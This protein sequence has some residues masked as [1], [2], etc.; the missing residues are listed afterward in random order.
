[1]I[2]TNGQSKPRERQPADRVDF[3]CKAKYSNTLPDLPFEPKFLQCPFVSLNRFVK[4]RPTTLE[5]NYKYE[6]L[7]ESDLNV[8]IDLIDPMTYFN[9]YDKTPIHPKDE[10]LLEDESSTQQNTKRSLQHSRIV[11]WM[12]KTEYISTEFNRF[13][14]GADRQ[15]SKIGYSIKKKFGNEQPF[16]NRQSQINAISKTFT[17]VKVPA[18]KHYS[19]PGVHAV[20]EIPLLPD[21]EMWPYAFALVIFQG[22][23]LPYQ[24]ADRESKLR[25][26]VIKGMKDS[27]NNQFVGYFAP[28]AS[29][30]EQIAEDQKEEQRS[31]YKEDF[32]YEYDLAREYTWLDKKKDTKELEAESYFFTFRNKAVYFNKLDTRVTLVR[33]PKGQL[34]NTKKS[35]LSIRHRPAIPKEQK[36][37]DTRLHQLLYPYEVLEEDE[38]EEEVEEEEQEEANPEEEAAQAEK[39]SQ[40]VEPM[41]VDEHAAADKASTSGE[42]ED[43]EEVAVVKKRKKSTAEEEES[44][45]ASEGE[46]AASSKNNDSEDEEEEKPTSQPKKA[47]S[48]SSS[49][50]EEEEDDE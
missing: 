30:L 41:E 25:H 8:K 16:K 29:A 35:I 49:E 24:K 10:K 36:A 3:I 4:Y 26:A 28:T 50:E 17:D 45:S 13:G 7:T 43:E 44:S 19:K 11:P 15:E 2:Q 40:A 14:V 42:E 39:K 31:S 18:K 20:E 32:L 33:R 12:R 38:E 1:M 21:F 9:P 22:D 48:S 37:M 5:K 46:S 34:D 23:P 27:E 47:V 6:L